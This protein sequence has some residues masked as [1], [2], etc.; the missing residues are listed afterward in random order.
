MA[1]PYVL[2]VVLAARFDEVDGAHEIVR[3]VQHRRLHALADGLPAGKVDDSIKSARPLLLIIT[4]PTQ[5]AL[6]G[7]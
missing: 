4:P 6:A 1:T 7:R 5:C 3:V 2:Q